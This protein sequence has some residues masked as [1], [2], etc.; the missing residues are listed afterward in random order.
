MKTPEPIE[1]TDG[2][3]CVVIA[4]MKGVVWREDDERRWQRLLSLQARVRD[5]IGIMGLQLEVD[6][7]EGYAL[8]R[9]P[10]ADDA[11]ELPRLIPRRPLTRVDDRTR[12]VLGWSN[13]EK[14]AAVELARRAV[15]SKAQ[16]LGEAIAQVQEREGRERTQL[17]ALRAVATHQNFADLDWRQSVIDLQQLEAE[18]DAL[19][20]ASDVLRSLEKQLRALEKDLDEC[21]A[22]L[23]VARER[24][25]RADERRSGLER[26]LAKGKALVDTAAEN[27]RARFPRLEELRAEYGRTPPLTIDNGE[28]V[29]SELRTWLQS[30]IDAD[31]LRLDRLRQKIVAAMQDYRNTF[32]LETKEADASVEAAGEFRK[33]L[34]KLVGDDL[35]RFERKFKELLNENTIREVANFQSQLRRERQEISER[36]DLINKSLREIPFNP[37]RF[38]RLESANATD[39]EVRDFQQDL[40]V[41]PP[42]RGRAPVDGERRIRSAA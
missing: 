12:Y 4:L 16:A 14:L 10:P 42:D 36:I 22:M 17:E 26:A 11:S 8:L 28:S 41:R 2:L 13:A 25:A 20:R 27:E 30:R 3:P 9:Q 38:I 33:M 24:R 37:G 23:T 39:V 32:P 1:A 7:N 21:E 31:G 34:T 5:H 6:E 18:L 40:R 35:P 29:E 19:A 15:E